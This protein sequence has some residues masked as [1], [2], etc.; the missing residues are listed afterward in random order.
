MLT[1]FMLF[2]YVSAFIRSYV[3]TVNK[4]ALNFKRSEW[5]IAS[6]SRRLHWE[7]SI[8]NDV[9]TSQQKFRNSIY[10]SK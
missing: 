2:C 5:K 8:E 10:I 7:K 1:T 4:L 3:L 9:Y 6:D